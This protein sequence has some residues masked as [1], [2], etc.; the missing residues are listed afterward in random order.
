[1]I[2]LCVIVL[3][4]FLVSRIGVREEHGSTRRAPEGETNAQVIL[5]GLRLSLTNHR[6]MMGFLTRLINTAPQFGMFIILPTVIAETLGWGQSR[7]LLMTSVASSQRAWPQP[8]R[9]E[10]RTS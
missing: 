9:S 10:E 5:A 2:A 3:A 6:V 4:G 8:R 1:M 7:W